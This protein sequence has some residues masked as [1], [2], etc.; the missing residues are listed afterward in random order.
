M[1]RIAFLVVA[2]VAPA[3]KKQEADSKSPP[4]TA[5]SSEPGATSPEPGTGPWA[6]WNMAARRAAFEGAHVTPGDM[7]GSWQ[8]WNVAGDKVTTWDGQKE[9]T[10]ELAVISPCEVK[11]IEKSESGSSSTTGHYTLA[12]GKLIQGLGDAGSRHGGEAVACVSNTVFTLDAKGTCTEWS[13]PMFDGG[14]YEQKP[15]TCGFRKEGGNEVFA[16]TVGGHETLLEVHGDA[17]TS[18][19][20]WQTHSEKLADY[21]AAKAAR[22]AKK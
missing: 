13:A 1:K 16:V 3:C 18:S 15:G 22:D 17:L 12:D 21:A 7:L 8:A 2:V 11:I 19:Q 10:L 20:L 9:K 4:A 14:K 6:S 5:K